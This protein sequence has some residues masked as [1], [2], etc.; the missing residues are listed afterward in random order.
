MTHSSDI[1]HLLQSLLLEISSKAS[2]RLQKLLDALLDQRKKEVSQFM[3]YLL[4]IEEGKLDPA[5]LRKQYE[6][7]YKIR[8]SIASVPVEPADNIFTKAE[9]K[10]EAYTDNPAHP[11][12]QADKIIKGWQL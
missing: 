1:N 11:F 7:R 4:L 9:K 6:E 8:E 10:A 12:S 3:D 2:L 5:L